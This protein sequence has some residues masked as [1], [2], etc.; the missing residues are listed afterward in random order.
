MKN[1]PFSIVGG[2]VKAQASIE[3]LWIYILVVIIAV[4]AA[5]FIYSVFANANSLLPSKCVFDY[6]IQCEGIIE[7]SN[8]SS[9][10]IALLGTNAQPY[11]IYSPVL[12]INQSGSSLE[13]NCSPSIV[14]PGQPILC[15]GKMQKL[16]PVFGYESGTTILKASYCGYNCNQGEVQESFIGN[17][18]SN[19]K[20]LIVPKVSLLIKPLNNYAKSNQ[21][22]TIQVGLDIFGYILPV[23]NPDLISSNPSI[24]IL[25][26]AQSLSN[27]F[28][29]L[30]S[31]GTAGASTVSV[32]YAGLNANTTIVFIPEYPKIL[33]TNLLSSNI[34]AIN[35]SNGKEI[36]F[37]NFSLPESIAA[38]SNGT[39]AYI[40]VSGNKVKM[41]NLLNGNVIGS[42][43]VGSYPSAILDEN[44]YLYIANSGSNNVT[45]ARE[46]GS[47]VKSISTGIFPDYEAASGNGAYVFV[48]NLLSENVTMINSLSIAKSIKLNYVPYAIASNY[49]GSI[50]YATFPAIN[51]VSAISTKNGSVLWQ[52]YAGLI[53]FGISYNS[54]LNR[55]YVT[56][57]GTS[58]V[59]VINASTGSHIG[60][61]NVGFLPMF[62]STSIDNNYEYVLNLGSDTL[63]IINASSSGVVAT[64]PTGIFPS[65]VT[66]S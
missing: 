63:S 50:I 62:S 37:S 44:G 51:Q 3:Y 25:Y 39:I 2:G 41:L 60:S 28:I 64:Y 38:S 55:L 13:A 56:D 34:T 1:Y 61:I 43:K 46:N 47:I 4:V 26:N 57:I 27:G 15:I 12:Y 9:T 54:K 53:P 18:S 22:I 10:M 6:G 11:P 17:Y 45:I 65:W 19:I 59:S 42:I 58:S 8:A 66:E 35:A 33:I 31:N 32:S 23:A 21:N 49:N 7:A 30:T 24:S 29:T 14:K 36:T 16:E 48:L 52:A 5:Y 20:R 40:A